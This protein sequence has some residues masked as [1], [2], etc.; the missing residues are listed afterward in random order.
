MADELGHDIVQVGHLLGTKSQHILEGLPGSAALADV[1]HDHKAM[2][3]A[4]HERQ[5]AF[6]PGN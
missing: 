2:V 5:Q 3:R 6:G 1:I 4:N